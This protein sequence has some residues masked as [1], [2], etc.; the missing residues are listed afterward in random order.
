MYIISA[1]PTFLWCRHVSLQGSMRVE[2]MPLWSRDPVGHYGGHA[3]SA[4]SAMSLT[5]STRAPL[6][7]LQTLHC[8]RLP[9]ALSMI[10]AKEPASEQAVLLRAQEQF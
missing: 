4:T 9:A 7:V 3:L 10:A 1:L 2:T 6:S 8:Q 5:S